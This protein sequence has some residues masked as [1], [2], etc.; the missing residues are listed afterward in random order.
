VKDIRKIGLDV[1]FRDTVRLSLTAYRITRSSTVIAPDSGQDAGGR[2]STNSGASCF[3]SEYLY[4]LAPPVTNGEIYS[5]IRSRATMLCSSCTNRLT[6]K[7]RLCEI[8]VANARAKPAIEAE[9]F[10][11]KR[12]TT[13]VTPKTMADRKLKRAESHLLTV[14]DV[15]DYGWQ[16]RCTSPRPVESEQIGIRKSHHLLERDGTR[17]EGTDNGYTRDRFTKE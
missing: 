15:S 3:N 16:V 5:L 11:D 14:L 6:T 9:I 4:G 1:S 7:S 8:V 13:A 17:S 2:G 12:I 10:G